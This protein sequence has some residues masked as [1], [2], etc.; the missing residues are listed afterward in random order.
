MLKEIYKF[1]FRRSL[2]LLNRHQLGSI[3]LS[4]IKE[5]LSESEQKERNASINNSFKH[6]ERIIKESIDIQKDFLATGIDNEEDKIII[7]GEGTTLPTLVGRSNINMAFI[8]LDKIKE[9]K[10][11][12][13]ELS[14]PKE[15]FNKHKVF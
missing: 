11:A 12:H 9:Y 8:L 10:S 5:K 4:D 14:K 7:V 13:E 6:L 15:D 2:F 3:D 1:L